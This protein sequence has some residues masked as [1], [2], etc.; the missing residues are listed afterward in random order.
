M[1]ELA[2]NCFQKHADSLQAEDPKRME[3]EDRL[4]ETYMFLGEVSIE[5]ENYAQSVEDL[6]SCLR[7]RQE[8]L[9]DDSRSIAETHYQVSY[10][11]RVNDT[12][13]TLNLYTFY[14]DGCCSGI[15]PGL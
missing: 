5:N 8:L 11:I 13:N 4:C 7:R 9:P 1:L 10:K 15:Q 14:L 3:M 12:Q 2:K 6:T